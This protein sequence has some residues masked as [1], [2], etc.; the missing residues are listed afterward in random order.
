MC[1]YSGILLFVIWT[2]HGGLRS[3]IGSLFELSSGS[4]G[5]RNKVGHCGDI[6]FYYAIFAGAVAGVVAVLSWASRFLPRLTQWLPEFPKVLEWLLELVQHLII[7]LGI[8]VYLLHRDG[9][10]SESMQRD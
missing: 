2:S 1:P 5:L 8:Y 10:K 6:F 7:F 3:E 4:E 9:G